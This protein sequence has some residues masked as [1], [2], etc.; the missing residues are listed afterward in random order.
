VANDTL[1]TKQIGTIWRNILCTSSFRDLIESWVQSGEL[2]PK[3]AFAKEPKSKRKARADRAAK[4]AAEAEQMMAEIKRK[5]AA[6]SNQ[7]EGWCHMN[8]YQLNDPHIQHLSL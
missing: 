8:P 3:A 7:G 5:A 6:Q 4:E 1:R 2:S